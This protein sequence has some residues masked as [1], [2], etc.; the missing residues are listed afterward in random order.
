MPI[1]PQETQLDSEEKN[2]HESFNQNEGSADFRRTTLHLRF[3]N[4]LF[5]VS[6]IGV[7]LHNESS[8][9]I[10]CTRLNMLDNGLDRFLNTMTEVYIYIYIVLYIYIYIKY[11]IL[12]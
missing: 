3:N 5:T 2:H 7:G 9:L 10:W 4:S 8:E 1:F 6:F 12:S 11:E